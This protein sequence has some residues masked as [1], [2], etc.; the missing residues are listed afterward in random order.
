MGYPD[1]FI[2]AR[3]IG[4]QS[5]S[6]ERCCRCAR[7]SDRNGSICADERQSIYAMRLRHVNQVQM[8]K[9]GTVSGGKVPELSEECFDLLT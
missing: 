3:Q 5:S 9:L 8:K 7:A 2:E 4:F 6:C 1:A